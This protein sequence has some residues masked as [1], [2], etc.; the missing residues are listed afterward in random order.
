MR[1]EPAIAL[2]EIYSSETRAQVH[3]DTCTLEFVVAWFAFMVVI[4]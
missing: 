1:F 2:L 4:H 3:K